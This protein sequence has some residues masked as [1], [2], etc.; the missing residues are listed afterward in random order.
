MQKNIIII[1][2]LIMLFGFVT[3]FHC[4]AD[5]IAQ[6][7]I[8]KSKQFF[9]ISQDDDYDND[10]NSSQFSKIKFE[11]AFYLTDTNGNRI[12]RD[13]FSALTPIGKDLYIAVKNS[14]YG[15]INSKGK[16]VIPF[17]YDFIYMEHDGFFAKENIRGSK[18][19][20][21][22]FY[23]NTGKLLF[24]TKLKI[25][26]VFVKPSLYLIKQNAYQTIINS[27]D[28]KEIF[29]NKYSDIIP[30]KYNGDTIFIAAKGG[31]YG[32]I[33]ENE[34]VKIPFEYETIKP[35]NFSKDD[36]WAKKDG[37]YGLINLNNEIKNNFVF[38]TIPQNLA[39]NRF[40]SGFYDEN[41]NE[42]DINK[43]Q[44]PSHWEYHKEL[45]PEEK[46][47]LGIDEQI[48]IYNSIKNKE[49]KI[50]IKPEGELHC[51]SVYEGNHTKNENEPHPVTVRVTTKNP[52]TLFLS[53]Y[54]L[55]TWKVIP[56]KGAKINK[57]Y[58]SSYENSEV[59]APRGI[60]TEKISAGDYYEK[61]EFQKLIN[62]SETPPA[63]FQT[64]YSVR[65]AEEFLIDGKDGAKYN[66]YPKHPVNNKSVSLKCD[67]GNCSD[68]T[69]NYGNKGASTTAIAN[70]Y[71]DSGKYYFEAKFIS[72]KE[73]STPWLNIGLLSD[74]NGQS[75]VF[76]H[77]PEE[78]GCLHISI[79]G[80]S[81]HTLKNGDIVGI[82]AD[83]DEGKLYAFV[84][85]KPKNGI[86]EKK[87]T[88]YMFEPGQREYA[89]GFE[90]SDDIGWE[91]NFGA[92][93]FK[94]KIPE[95]FKPYDEYSYNKKKQF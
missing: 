83:F 33:T 59:K 79:M 94:Y 46:Y 13:K 22:F 80:W 71:Y 35:S 25:N 47:A 16:K 42:T 36:F 12:S 56:E 28:G 51:V 74:Y 90:A 63:T 65:G 81:E 93:K 15:V 40:I 89:A 48:E 88:I 1:C 11:P 84:N 76:S 87:K 32:I 8:L 37:K 85:G 72:P 23:D 2:F 70:K 75:C 54:S 66:F 45:T 86:I 49:K 91:V 14:K 10:K 64:K 26:P 27:S 52:I 50:L 58:Y 69:V 19:N 24:R 30:L 4:G 62:M 7:T 73:Y 21:Y 95:G 6:S 53:S 39:A 78:T 43:E 9:G 41:E 5:K 20:Y 55:V 44:Q 82:A 34:E 31:K 77:P 3:I 17:K 92:K 38:N 60:K 18:E 57:I 29:K 68:L 61:W 67:L